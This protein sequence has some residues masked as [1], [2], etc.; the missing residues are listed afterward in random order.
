MIWY[1]WQKTADAKMGD[2]GEGNDQ[3]G[4]RKRA[5]APLFNKDKA[6]Y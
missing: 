3:A 5:A 6:F 4:K 1:F 2:G